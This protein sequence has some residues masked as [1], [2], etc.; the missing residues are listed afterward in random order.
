MYYLMKG[1]VNDDE[2]GEG[3]FEWVLEADS[4]EA[5][6]AQLDENEI[7]EEIREISVE[8]RIEREEKALFKSIKREYLE[9]RFGHCMVREFA[10][11]Q[12]EME[13]NPEMYYKAL[14]EYNKMHRLMKRLNRRNGFEKITIAQFFDLVNKLIDAQ[15][16]EEFNS[17]LHSVDN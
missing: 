15:T 5:A 11:Y 14:V 8:E 3:S 16:E 7:V 2:Y 1:T 10:K 13:S 6:K 9:R 17:I 4:V 12:R